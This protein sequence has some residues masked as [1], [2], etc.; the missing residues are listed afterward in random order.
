[1][2]DFINKKTTF[3]LLNIYRWPFPLI[4]NKIGSG[5]LTQKCIYLFKNKYFLIDISQRYKRKYI[6]KIKK[7]KMSYSNWITLSNWFL[8]YKINGRRRLYILLY[9]ILLYYTK[10]IS[11]KCIKDILT[12]NFMNGPSKLSQLS[13]EESRLVV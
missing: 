12:C 1:M 6:L 2:F 3:I 8:L 10:W 7:K 5:I 11:I 9:I 4:T 13:M